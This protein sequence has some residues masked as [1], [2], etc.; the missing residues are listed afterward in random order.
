MP[1]RKLFV[2]AG[3]LYPGLII[4]LLAGCPD[5]PSGTTESETLA[6]SSTTSNGTDMSTTAPTTGVEVCPAAPEPPSGLFSVQRGGREEMFVMETCPELT[7]GG[8]LGDNSIF[9][10]TWRPGKGSDNASWPN[11]RFPV[12]VFSPGQGQGLFNDGV[13]LFSDDGPHNSWNGPEGRLAA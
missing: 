3:A 5:D 1:N 7:N 12:V 9:I 6:A 4:T 13:Q 11:G 2:F 10:E 8:W